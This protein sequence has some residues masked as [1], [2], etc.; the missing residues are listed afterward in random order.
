MTRYKTV[1]RI[2]LAIAMVV[3]GIKHFT[4][5]APFVSI[6][7]SSLPHPLALVYGSGFFEILG[8]AGLLIPQFSRAAAW[9]L[10]ILFIA[11]FPANLYQAMHNIPV[12]ALPNDPP[13]I[14]LRLPFQILLVVWA[15]WLTRQDSPGF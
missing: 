5:P 11:V 15:G 4:D 8:G 2:F 1:F 12:P 13:L 14:W 3:I 6:V 7:P 10:V 9:I